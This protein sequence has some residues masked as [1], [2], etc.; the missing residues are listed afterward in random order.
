MAARPSPDA[1]SE[2]SDSAISS[3]RVARSA[4]V[5]MGGLATGIVVGLIRSRV[6]A[7]TFG[8]SAQ[9]DA[10]NSANTIPELL[11]IALAGP[12][13]S[14]AFI[15]VYTGLLNDRVAANRLFSHVLTSVF[16]VM[17]AVSLMT[18]LFA[19]ILVSAPW[20]IAPGFSPETQVVTVALMRLLFVATTLFALSG[21]VTGSL[22]AHQHFLLP[23]LAPSAYGIGII[24]GALVFS[25]WLGVYGLAWG[26]ILGACLH[27]GVQLPAALRH[28][29]RWSPAFGW[30][31]PALRRVAILMAPR[32]LDLILARISIQWIAT[33]IASGLGEGRVSA[34]QY[35]FQL[36]NMP[37]T[38]IGT[39]IGFAVFP[40]MA[41][42]ASRKDVDA[43][44]QALS[45]S[46]RAIL[47]LA[48]P[49]SAALLLLGRP[50]IE[51]LYEGGEFTPQSTELVLSA[52][53]AYVV[54]LISLS[55]LEVVVRAYAAQ[56]DT[57]TPLL[58]SFF[59]TAL[60]IGLAFWLASTPLQHAGPPLAYGLAV[61][62]EVS[63]GL[64]ILHYRWQGIYARRILLDVGRASL[65]TAGMVG[66]ILL[67]GTLGPL[68]PVVTLGIG[69]LVG[70]LVYGGLALALGIQEIREIPLDLVRGL[71]GRSPGT[72]DG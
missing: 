2:H 67:L 42:L 36:M 3:G 71:L 49:A 20:G 26:A 31:D 27:L 52:L 59:T 50:I 72:A 57:L 21:I 22:H 58:V 37:Q 33:N 32:V 18:G 28:K 11:V 40:T 60:N 4:L 44:R 39:A 6:V 14:F 65:A 9:L 16:V 7:I 12:A 46:L 45:G 61:L 10:F 48:I 69:G 43:Q 41:H 13:L 8:T 5:V 54:A 17:V 47:T 34:V 15:P 53:R 23:A 1:P 24:I 70:S 38:L 63:I 64:L 19:P 62:A 66:V 51:V 55:M 56:Q 35:G 29:L 30:N 25:R 68:P